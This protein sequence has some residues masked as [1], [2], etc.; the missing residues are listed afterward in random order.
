MKYNIK[1]IT[2]SY[3]RLPLTRIIKLQIE[4]YCFL[5]LTQIKLIINKYKLPK[6]YFQR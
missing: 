1:G 6:F 5:S 4:V 2:V 3:F